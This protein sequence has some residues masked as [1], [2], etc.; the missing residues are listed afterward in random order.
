MS[1]GGEE[2]VGDAAVDNRDVLIVSVQNRVWSIDWLEYR[3]LD[4]EG[5]LVVFWVELFGSTVDTVSWAEFALVNKWSL[6]VLDANEAIFSISVDSL[7]ALTILEALL[8]GP[9]K[10][11]PCTEVSFLVEVLLDISLGAA[12]PEALG[13]WNIVGQIGDSLDTVLEEVLFSTDSRG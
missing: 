6:G 9:V 13:L 10:L 8:L 3:K 11:E 1:L 2:T 12:L 4:T 7:G 5:T